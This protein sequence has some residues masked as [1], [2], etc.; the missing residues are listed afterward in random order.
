MK[1]IGGYFELAEKDGFFDLPVSGV[2][3]NTAR[4]ALE[5][6]LIQLPN[7]K[8]VYLPLYT[9]EAVVEPLT[10]MGLSHGFYTINEKLEIIQ[11]PVLAEGEYLIA[12]NYFG[13]KDAYIAKLA[14]KYGERLI[15]DNAQAL[16]APV[17]PGTHACYSTR[18]YVGVADGG[19]A[20]GVSSA[21]AEGYERDNSQEHDSHLLI[22]KTN[23]AEAGFK[24]YQRNECK[25]NN[26]PIRRMS[27][28]TLTIL[29]SIDY[30]KVIARRKENF[31]YLHKALKNHNEIE[32]PEQDT[33]V[34]P[35]VYPF[36]N[37]AQNDLRAK[38]ILNKVFVARYW[39]NVLEW[40]SEGEQEMKLA[41][42]LL[43]LPI[44]QRYGVEDMDRIISLI[45]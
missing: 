24:D 37:S 36:L 35:M 7:V 33:F 3:L 8:K 15:V 32:I 10:R 13:L 1:A 27:Q 26:Q 12:N 11:E 16:F 40:A 5:Y 41:D 28:E 38:L 23:G 2:C 17:I 18:K 31:E 43:P 30:S 6:I 42:A 19:I 39:P 34:C 25:L 44:D 4:N 21:E 20:T 9:C 22:R 29:S 14:K 45:I